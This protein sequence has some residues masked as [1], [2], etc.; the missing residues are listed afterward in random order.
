MFGSLSTAAGVTS[1]TFDVTWAYP[2]TGVPIFQVCGY[3]GTY[4][5]NGLPCVAVTALSAQSATVAIFNAH[6]ANALSGTV[7]LSYLM[8]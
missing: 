6:G 5:T 1:A 3:T 4:T 8:A 2:V 7:T